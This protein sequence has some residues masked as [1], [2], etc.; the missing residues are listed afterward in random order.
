MTSQSAPLSARAYLDS[1]PSFS[2]RLSSAVNRAESGAPEEG[3]RPAETHLEEEIAEIKR[4]EVGGYHWRFLVERPFT[5]LESD[6]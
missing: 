2:H 6:Y 4:Y 3:H 1:R 5:I